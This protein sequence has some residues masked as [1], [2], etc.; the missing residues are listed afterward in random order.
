MVDVKRRYDGRRRQA[1]AAQRRRRMLTEARQLLLERGYADTTLALVAER[2]D[3]ATPTVYKA[4]GN[5]AGLIKAVI[6]YS[7]AGDDDPTPILRRERAERIRSEPDPVRKIELYSDGLIATLERS[8]R[9]QLIVRAAADNQ[10]EI[11]PVWKRMQQERLAG[12]TQLAKVFADG[13]HLAAGVT[14]DEAR[15]ILWVQ[16]SPELYQLFVVE[17]R[18]SL[19]RYRAWLV[20]TLTTAL[21]A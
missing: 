20:T 10:P 3:V 15:D 17:R 13:G 21:V 9:L 2:A 14:A 5:K 7:V 1:Q 11:R 4:F 6:D 19:Q 16:T 12:M 8:G 18:W